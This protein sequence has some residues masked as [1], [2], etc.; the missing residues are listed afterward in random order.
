MT[1][2]VA[3]WGDERLPAFFWSVAMMEPNSGCWLRAGVA[4]RVSRARRTAYKAL[5]GPIADRDYLGSSCG[6]QCIN[7]VHAKKATPVS[8]EERSR[9]KSEQKQRRWAGLSLEQKRTCWVRQRY[10]LAIAD[11]NRMVSDQGNACA[12]CRRVFG[13]EVRRRPHVDHCHR[14]RKVRALLCVT[15][16]T[17]I[18]SLNDDPLLLRTAALYLEAH[19]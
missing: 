14:T 10:G 12:I 9:H 1:S 18:G 15:C 2:P 16:N 17:A 7:P 19:K 8:R 13:S 5:I 6:G 3:D 11:Y 4:P